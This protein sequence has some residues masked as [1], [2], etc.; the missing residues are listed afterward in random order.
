MGYTD[1]MQFKSCVNVGAKK[2]PGDGCF[3]FVAWLWQ[4]TVCF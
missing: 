3:F 1:P 4:E 2:P